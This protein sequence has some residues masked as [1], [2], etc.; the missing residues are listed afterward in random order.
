M[1]DYVV[2]T[3]VWAMMDKSIG[4]M[5]KI[6]EIECI[7]N[8]R[9]WLRDFVNSTD[10]LVLDDKHLILREYRNNMTPGGRAREFLNTLET[11]PREQRLVELAIDLDKDGYAVVPLYLAIND[12]DDRKFIAVAL[13]HSPT[14]PIVNATDTDWAK[15]KAMLDP[16]GIIIQEI[17]DDY[18]QATLK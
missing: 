6:E 11:K 15:D 2:D 13:A 10:R 8:C 4:D 5:L 7:R 9:N 1:A 14:P 17:C 18:I 16:G 12:K 3:N